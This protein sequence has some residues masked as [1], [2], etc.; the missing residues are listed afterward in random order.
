[1]AYKNYLS[2]CDNEM[3]FIK[4]QLKIFWFNCWIYYFFWL[5]MSIFS[6]F[7]LNV[8]YKS[9]RFSNIVI[10][11]RIEFF[12]TNNN[13]N[14]SLNFLPLLL[15]RKLY[16]IFLKKNGKKNWIKASDFENSK[17]F[18]ILLVQVIALYIKLF[19]V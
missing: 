16:P 6:D 4:I 5:V 8:M 10:R 7:Y 18:L 3:E 15:S 13:I 17:M 19:I 14:L 2:K 1:M 9:P 12:S 11:N